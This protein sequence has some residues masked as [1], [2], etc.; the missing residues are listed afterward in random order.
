MNHKIGCKINLWQLGFFLLLICCFFL[1]I[2][3]SFQK[4]RNEFLNMQMAEMKYNLKIMPQLQESY[5]KID[6]SRGHVVFVFP[7]NF[8]L[9]CLQSTL[10][11]I[12]MLEKE[13]KKNFIAVV[14]VAN[15]VAFEVYN[16]SFKMEFET[17]LYRDYFKK[18]SVLAG[19]NVI[20]FYCNLSG[21]IVSPM[22]LTPVN[23]D[24]RSYIYYWS[25]LKR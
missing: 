1:F 2:L 4:K 9:S 19:E 11:N 6:N 13:L 3:F 23:N 22:I 10:Q 16:K 8:C 21:D 17:V 25:E 14:P 5:V 24:I 7:E 12:G 18:M 20:M 15:K